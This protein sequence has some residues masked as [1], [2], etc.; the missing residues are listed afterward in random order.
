MLRL[1]SIN[2]QCTLLL[3][4][5]YSSLK[6]RNSID[7]NGITQITSVETINDIINVDQVPVWWNSMHDK[8]RTIAIKG[9]H[10][11]SAITSLPGTDKLLWE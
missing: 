11:V 10:K 2:S 4:L 1:L 5:F 8:Q 6:S 3:I 9:Q 7:I